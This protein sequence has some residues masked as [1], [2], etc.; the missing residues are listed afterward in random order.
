MPLFSF[1]LLRLS[2]KGH[3]L[4]LRVI[5]AVVLLVALFIQY[6]VW[7]PS[8]T[9]LRPFEEPLPGSISHTAQ[10]AEAFVFTLLMVQLVA[11]VV[12]TPIVIVGSICEEI[13]RR[14]IE[15]LFVTE[16]T[17]FQIVWGKLGARLIFL[18]S[19]VLTGLPITTLSAFFGGVSLAGLVQSY[20]VL[21]GTL[22]VLASLS[23]MIVVQRGKFGSAL[24]T[25]YAVTILCFWLGTML[26]MGTVGD[27]RPIPLSPPYFLYQMTQVD[28]SILTWETPAFVSGSLLLTFLFTRAAVKPFR[29]AILAAQNRVVV[30]FES[31]SESAKDGLI[32]PDP[33]EPTELLVTSPYAVVPELLDVRIVYR[34][35]IDDHDPIYWKE[36]NF[37]PRGRSNPRLGCL[38]TL[39]ISTSI[40]IGILFFL[41]LVFSGNR[42]AWND[43]ARYGGF[44]MIL[45][46]ATLLG[47]RGIRTISREREQ[48]TLLSLLLI[49]CERSEILAAK[50][51]SVGQASRVPILIL[52]FGYF[53][54]VF[55][56]GTSPFYL[57][58]AL[59]YAFG[60]FL[61][62]ANF[63]VWLSCWHRSSRRAMLGYF[64]SLL[65]FCFAPYLFA[66][67]GTVAS[68][69]LSDTPEK[70]RA[71]GLFIR[72]LGPIETWFNLNAPLGDGSIPS[73]SILK[74]FPLRITAA[75]LSTLLVLCLSYLF[76][77]R[78]KRTFER[79][80]K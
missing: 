42:Y 12:L 21:L 61:L 30:S 25:I 34:K 11:I 65:F 28:P 76:W 38:F 22:L 10:F 40:C 63:S 46:G 23:L 68:R 3:Q 72:S 19:V 48:R 2:R 80:G 33:A 35:R 39:V 62:A 79:E 51:R 17:N 44:F 24:V 41:T 27:R 70:S 15:D 20:L 16:L 49:P 47:L 7:F 56:G 9:V 50:W 66:E 32:R 58:L 74:H 54:I 43:L 53:A 67:I 18:L 45:V 55:A 5:L 1:E 6:S 75:C 59:G 13:D 73:S 64:T 60:L 4:H 57:L 52:I 71:V 78:A 26:V 37:R 8:F 31:L 14:T 36:E 77:W 29:S 69:L